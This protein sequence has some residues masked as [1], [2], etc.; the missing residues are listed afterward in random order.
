[1]NWK[2]LSVTGFGER[3]SAHGVSKDNTAFLKRSSPPYDI[4]GL[5]TRY[6]L[7][8]IPLWALQDLERR[9]AK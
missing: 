1:M 9:E 4:I 5:V 3:Y 7:C 6:V 8:N 2:K